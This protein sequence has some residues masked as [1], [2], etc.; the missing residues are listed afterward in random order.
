MTKICTFLL[1]SYSYT[2]CKTGKYE[3][4]KLVHFLLYLGQNCPF[5]RAH[6]GRPYY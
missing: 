5:R 3:M 1:D 6:A 2:D 4:V